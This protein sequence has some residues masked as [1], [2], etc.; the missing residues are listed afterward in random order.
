MST[1]RALLCDL[2]GVVY[3]GDQ[4]CPG[5][6]EGLAA[7]RAAGVSVL[8]L[9]NN[10]GHTAQDVVARL[11]KLGVQADP[12][13]VLTSSMVAASHLRDQHLVPAKAPGSPPVVLAV[14]GPGVA[15]ALRT[16]GFTVVLPSET[17][18]AWS[19][20]EQPPAIGAVVQG[21]GPQV[22]ALDLAEATFAI[23]DGA[24]WV[25]TNSDATLPSE[26]GFAPGNGALLQAVAHALGREPDMVVGKPHAPAYRVASAMLGLAPEE[27][28]AVGD[29][30]DTDIVGAKAAGMRTALVLT[31]VASRE[32][33]ESAPPEARP[34]LV[35][36]DLAELARVVWP[37]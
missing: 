13:E 12:S 11:E 34:D 5:A 16:V 17:R 4:P 8:F 2:D 26:R 15:H 14:G 27:V 22:S 9:T 1:P 36:E 35:L 6:V 10:A 3:R 28:L 32:E 33:G 25:A 30:L 18:D 29:R 24:A 7:I 20:G 19:R 23:A 37:G 21:Y 31:G